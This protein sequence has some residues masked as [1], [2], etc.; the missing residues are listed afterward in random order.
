[1]NVPEFLSR[2]RAGCLLCGI[3]FISAFF[4]LWNI[5]NQGISNTYYAAAVK[6]MLVNPG[7][8]FFNSFDPARFYHD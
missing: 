5:A 2:Y 6:S 7:I 3:L 4:N 1:M 8:A